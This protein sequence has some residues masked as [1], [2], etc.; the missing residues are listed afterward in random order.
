MATLAAACAAAPAPSAPPSNAA[1]R[2]PVVSLRD[3]ITGLLALA[4]RH[5]PVEATDVRDYLAHRATAITHARSSLDIPSW[6]TSFGDS[7]DTYLEL[8]GDVAGVRI[9]YGDR[10]GL[11]VELY[12]ANGTTK[13]V[14]AASGP[15]RATPRIHFDSPQGWIAYPIVNQ[16]TLR[17]LV[18]I[19]NQRM[20][21]S[22]HFEH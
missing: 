19:S 4:E 1:R 2:V 9:P 3:E 21:V 18:D 16:H 5:W 22:L 7:R 8:G 12:V 20:V 11:Y 14:E 13:D 10:D 6:A 17:V 15:L